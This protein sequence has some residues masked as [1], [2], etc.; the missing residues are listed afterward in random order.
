MAA[1]AISIVRDGLVKSWPTASRGST[2]GSS[3]AIDG[4]KRTIASSVTPY[5]CSPPSPPDRATKVVGS[6]QRRLAA[7]VLRAQT[8]DRACEVVVDNT[9]ALS[10]HR[11]GMP[12]SDG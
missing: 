4:A 12:L 10:G 2:S 11:L 3:G 6:H 5:E 8:L 7:R 9:D 1:N